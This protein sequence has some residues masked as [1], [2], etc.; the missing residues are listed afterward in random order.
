MKLSGSIIYLT[1]T[2]YSF[3]SLVSTLDSLLCVFIIRSGSL[4]RKME[5]FIRNDTKS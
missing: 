2:F 5:C 3:G 4:F 1:S